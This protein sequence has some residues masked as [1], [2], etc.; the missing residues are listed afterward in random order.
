MRARPVDSL[1][2]PAV[3][4]VFEPLTF[5]RG[6]AMLNRFVL[7]PL[8]NQQSHA[9]GSLSDE[10]YHWLRRRARGG[11]GATMTLLSAGISA[12]FVDDIRPWPFTVEARETGSQYPTRA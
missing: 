11:F 6:P 10:Q 12:A 9:D 5:K 7:A 2:E 3:A 4:S 8:T 1:G